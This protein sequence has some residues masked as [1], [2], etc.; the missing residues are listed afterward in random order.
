MTTN[1]KKTAAEAY[2]VR[3][4]SIAA[5]LAA[6]QAQL[7]A[8]AAKEAKDPTNWGL[9]GDLSHVDGALDGLAA[10]LGMEPVVTPAYQG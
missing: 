7:A 3:A 8:H 5:K 9:V 10:L 6:L 1:T 2:A 4:S